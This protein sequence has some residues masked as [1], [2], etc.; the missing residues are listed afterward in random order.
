M[1]ARRSLLRTLVVVAMGSL[2]SLAA[3]DFQARSLAGEQAQPPATPRQPLRLETFANRLIAKK[4]ESID[5][6]VWVESTVVDS[7]TVTVFYAHDQLALTTGASSLTVSLP[8]EGLMTFTFL[9]QN[10]GKSNI[11]VHATGIHR[12]TNERVSASGHIQGIEVQPGLLS[13]GL[14]FSTSLLGVIL[15]ALLTL[16]TTRLN[17][18]RQRHREDAQRRRWV[19]EDLPAQLASDRAAVLA[20][21]E[22]KFEAWRGKLLSEGY[23]GELERLAAPHSDLRDLGQQLMEMGLGLQEY[24]ERRLRERLD[25]PFQRQLADQLAD[26]IGKIG[27]L[28]GHR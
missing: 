21:R 11:L 26:H 17:E 16:G 23:Y 9:A 5:I 22:T 19:T 1:S 8:A 7:A 13:L 28:R 14:G 3:L 27:A 25:L 6:R 12:E 2:V 20:G 15:G 18:R 4:G 24:E 10:P